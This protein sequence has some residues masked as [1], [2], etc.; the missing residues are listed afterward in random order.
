ML[1]ALCLG[2]WLFTCF[3]AAGQAVVVTARVDTNQLVVGGSTTLHVLAQVV[4]GVRANADR[5]FSWYV[6]VVNTNG[7]SV[8]ANYGGM[9]RPASDQDSR[10]SSTGTSQGAN[11]RGIYDT[12]LN[13]PGAGTASAVELMSIPLNALAVGRTRL[14]VSA[15]TTV[16]ALSSDFLVAL[17]DGG[18]ATGGDYSAAFVDLEV[19]SGAACSIQ[20]QITSLGGNRYQVSFTPCAGRSHFVESLSVL[21]AGGSWQVLPG[22]PHNSGSILVTNT[23]P[24]AFFRV[25]VQ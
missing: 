25:R 16:P 14:A 4:P 11:R 1:A 8:G 23:G 7:A 21:G 24:N 18:V 12:F 2:A 20:E 17:R 15:G 9:I 5:I 3:S 10:T 6:D 22:A 13:L 19:S